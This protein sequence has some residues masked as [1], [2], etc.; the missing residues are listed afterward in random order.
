MPPKEVPKKK[1]E[2]REHNPDCLSKAE[3]RARKFRKA[4]LFDKFKKKGAK[5][6][7]RPPQNWNKV[8]CLKKVPTPVEIRAKR[9]KNKLRWKKQLLKINPKLTDAQLTVKRA[10]HKMQD[11]WC[12]RAYRNTVGPYVDKKALEKFFAD[13][14]K[15]DTKGFVDRNFKKPKTF[16]LCARIVT[17]RSRLHRRVLNTD[18]PACVTGDVKFADLKKNAEYKAWSKKIFDGRAVCPL[19]QAHAI[20]YLRTKFQAVPKDAATKFAAGK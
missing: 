12:W 19:T 14:S 20:L 9:A 3:R 16:N 13:N 8:F 1:K 5:Q 6:F 17:G 7:T 4:K 2:P 11:A 15:G 18:A 10:D